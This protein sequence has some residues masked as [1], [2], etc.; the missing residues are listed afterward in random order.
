MALYHTYRPQ[1]FKDLLGQDHV[2]QTLK[3]ALVSQKVAHGYLFA[4]PRGSGKT[5]TARILAKALNC[6]ELKDGE[7][8][9]DKCVNCILI[10]E[11][12]ALDILEIDAASNRGID[13]IRELREHVKFAP[14]QLKYRVVIIDEVHMLTKEAFNALLKTLE[15]PP[16]HVV[17]IMATTEAHK[18]SAT[19]L[20]RVQRFDFK[21]ASVDTLANNLLRIAK[22]EKIDLGQSGA[23]LLAKLA[24]G[25]FRDSITLLDQVSSNATQEIDEKYI[26]SILGLSDDELINSFFEAIEAANRENALAIID[27][28][29]TQGGDPSSFLSQA[30]ARARLLLRE[31][32]DAR[33]IDW[34]K[35]LLKANDQLK[36][37]PSPSLPLEIFIAEQTESNLGSSSL[38]LAPAKP[39][40]LAVKVEVETKVEPVPVVEEK[41]EHLPNSTIEDISKKEITDIV[42]PE[43]KTKKAPKSDFNENTWHEMVENLKKENTSLAAIL[44]DS[45]LAQA[46][47]EELTIA[48]KFKFHSDKITDRKNRAIIEAALL[49]LTGQN[50]KISCIVDPNFVKFREVAETTDIVADALSVFE[51]I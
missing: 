20:S 40:E 44:K 45:H 24:E 4:G 43:E 33:I 13:D 39:T 12:K 48:V 5:S 36:F 28:F 14:N 1:L 8:C 21:L 31:S 26:R 16:E 37:S 42:K 35:G 7:L 19:I 6:L 30:I 27:N 41:V 23:N 9:N 17:F 49:A 22:K 34:L 50:I 11:G 15:E 47:G 10:N 3:N 32:G 38:K 25:S 18:V 46:E 51:E 2:S 29:L